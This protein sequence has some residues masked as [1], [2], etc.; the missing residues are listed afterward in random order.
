MAEVLNAGALVSLAQL[1]S[2]LSV[3]TSDADDSMVLKIN[4]A[5]EQI[6]EYCSRSFALAALTE[7][8]AIGLTRPARLWLQRSPLVT[9]VSVLTDSQ[10]G[11]GA[12]LDE[13]V[14]EDAT[15]GKLFR[16]ARFSPTGLRQPGI[17]GDFEPGT[18]QQSLQV[19]YLGGFITRPMVD[20]AGAWPGATTSTS[21][22]V[23]VIPASRPTQLWLASSATVDGTAALAGSTGASEP[24][25]PASPAVGATLTDGEL[26]WTY[27]GTPA[28]AVNLPGAV[29]QVALQ[30]AGNMV[31]SR[32]QNTTVQSESLMSYSVTYGDA[33]ERGTLTAGMQ[34][35]LM[36]WRRIGL[37]AP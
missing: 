11:P 10:P 20:A 8:R 27:R 36:K 16:R 25:W 4:A 31:A 33:S 17:I 28:A 30:L 23:L 35:A 2:E 29:V 13:Y 6:E 24:S 9:L 12:V 5:S 15:K 26:T 7:Q 1:K 32:G 22:G 21:L 18:A 19:N 14:I 3:T 34:A 37:G